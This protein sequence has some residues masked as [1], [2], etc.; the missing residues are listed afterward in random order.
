[1][2]GHCPGL[3]GI[4]DEE[5]SRKKGISLEEFVRAFAGGGGRILQYRNKTDTPG[6]VLKISE[7]ILP[8]IDSIS[9]GEEFHFIMNDYARIAIR[10]GIPFHL[11][12][13]DPLPHG[14]SN[15]LFWGRSTHNM[16]EVDAALQEFP[17]P[18]YIGFGAMFPSQT[19]TTAAVATPAVDSVMKRWE[20]EIVFIGG[21]T[22]DNLLMLP[23]SP[24]IFHAVI[25]D[26]FR[27][28]NTPADV[29]RYTREFIGKLKYA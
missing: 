6:D 8:L 17:P 15:S 10:L 29:E 25:S 9:T 13:T 3:Y 24:R 11:G 14:Y 23:H 12:Q 4:Y 22:L 16:E 7:K 27:Y 18:D 5:T 2:N 20:K 28:G 21:I 1:M 19:K 26:F